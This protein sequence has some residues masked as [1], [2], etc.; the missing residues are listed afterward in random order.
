MEGQNFL[1]LQDYMKKNIFILIL[2][3]AVNLKAQTQTELFPDNLNIQP[4][5]ANTLEPRA[6]F[7]FHLNKNE[8]RLDAGTSVDIASLKIDSSVFSFG[9][10]M[11]TYTFLR[12]ETNFHFP[13]DAVDYLFGV[14]FGFKKKA[15]CNEYG[16]RARIS[17][18]SA[19]F[20]DGHYDGNQQ[21]WRD[22]RIPRVYS[23]EFVELMPFYK[24]NNLRVY[25]GFT[26]IFHVDP[27]SI[28]KDN[29]QLGFDYYF[30]NIINQN[31]TPFAGY[32]LKLIHNDKY[33]ANNSVIVGMK[34]GKPQGKGVS[35]YFNYYS[36]KNIH[37]EYFDYDSEYSAIGINLDL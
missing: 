31:I 2:V 5:A 30:K 8:L 35:V 9:A 34:F 17:H 33:T 23:R 25:G 22:G 24:F 20:V 26:Y 14:N 7:L 11:F 4:F 1:I 13:V 15:G 29:Y 3:F 32:D 16:I 21:G 36:G 19:H 27:I 28:K 6:G 37:G 10:D 12:G 18:I